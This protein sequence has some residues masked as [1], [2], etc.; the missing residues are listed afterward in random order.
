MVRQ[1]A[2]L[3]LA[4]GEHDSVHVVGECPALGCDDL[5]PERHG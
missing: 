3:A 2:E 5:Q 1:D 4:A